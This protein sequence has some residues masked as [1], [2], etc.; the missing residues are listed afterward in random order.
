MLRVNRSSTRVVLGV[1]ATVSAL[2]LTACGGNT[3]SGDA[4]GSDEAFTVQQAM[5]ETLLPGVPD[6]IVVIDSPH[7]DAL[8]ALGLTPVGA[9]ESAAGGGFPT[10]LADG[11]EATKGV[12]STAEPDIE[13]I[14]A[15]APDLIIGSKVRHE[16]IY[17]Q[18]S[19]IAPTVYSVNSG[20]D[21]QEQARVTAASVNK[22]KEM[23]D[24]LSGLA[25]RAV[26][27]G[28]DVGAEGQTVS[29]ARFRPA[30]FRLYGPN[31]F[32]GSILTQVGFK[33]GERDWN[34]YSMLELSTEYYDQIDG[35]I[36]FYTNPGGD[37]KA[38]TM[39]TVTGLWGS[40]SAVQSGKTFEV[41]DETWM[42]G[43]GVNGANI[44]LDQVS[45]ALT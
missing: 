32:S 27:V 9:T 7:L 4:A 28:K 18:L 11:L 43:I 42:V 20:T 24:L 36:I 6:R 22:S 44:I 31:T 1:V 37:P 39:N 40:L 3:S 8:V 10:Y 25:A 16:T 33:L 30:N 23:D 12:G 19:A 17:N 13:A 34:E 29:M 15:L 45:E 35:E 2:L 26:A 38:T 41:E 5:G 21:W 14:A